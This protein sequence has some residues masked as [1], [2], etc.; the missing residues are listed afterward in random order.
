LGEYRVFV[1]GV[2]ESGEP[3]SVEFRVKVVAP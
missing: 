2:P 3:T 1:K